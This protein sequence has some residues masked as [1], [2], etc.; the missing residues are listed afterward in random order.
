MTDLAVGAD[1]DDDGG[2]DRGAVWVLFLDTDGTVKGHQKISAAEGGFTGALEDNDAMGR[3]VASLGDIDSDGVTDL[4]VG[5]PGDDDEGS[6]RG[7]VWVL[8]QNAAPVVNETTVE[9]AVPTAGQTIS[10]SAT[11]ND[12]SGIAR[13]EMLFRGAGASSFLAHE[14][15]G[16][17]GSYRADIPDFAVGDRGMEYFIR[18]T[19][20]SGA[21]TRLPEQGI[22]SIPVKVSDLRNDEPQPT[23]SQESAYRLISIP[24]DLTDKS[25]RAVL[26][27]DLGAY[28]NTRWRFYELTPAPNPTQNNL[29]ELPDI[30]EMPPGKAFFLIVRDLDGLIDTGAG[31]SVRTDASFEILLQ[32]GWNLIGNPFNF[33]IPIGNLALGSGNLLDLRFLDGTWDGFTGGAIEPFEGYAIASEG[34]DILL[35]DPDITG[36][37]VVAKSG[38]GA[39]ALWSVR[40]LARSRHARDI[41]NVAAVFENASEQW[42][43]LDRPEPP[44][45]PGDYVSVYFTHPEW[46]RLFSRYSTDARPVPQGGAVWPFDVTTTVRDPVHLTFEGLADIPPEFEVW[47]VDDVVRTAQNLRQTPTYT[48]A[49]AP[50]SLQLIVGKPGFLDGKLAESREIPTTFELFPNFP[51]PF[52]PSTTIRYGVPEAAAVS[53]VVYNML[54]QKVATLMHGAEQPAGFHAAVWDGRSDAGTQVAGG[55]YFVRMRAGRFMQTQK[56]VLVK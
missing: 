4:A 37:S 28:D 5:A 8:F 21:V 40:I 48:V 44:A 54:G 29:I 7:A 51:N 1:Q 22:F 19:D 34:A 11:V 35:L 33:P 27:D 20:N 50:R 56:M 3:S 18:A 46:H 23:G 15:V 32:P 13:V 38:Q 53:L 30:A 55:V 14:M 47:L 39:A 43:R 6:D 42:D 16:Q 26:E 36:Q 17:N 12:D 2:A 25:P 52:N 31:T 49:A 45:P 10:V 9:T 24:L 41:D